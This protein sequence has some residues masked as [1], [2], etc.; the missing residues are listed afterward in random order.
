MITKNN[1]N[2][3]EIN[4]GI[5]F[6]RVILSFMVI[7]DHFYDYAI[8]SKYYYI[9]YYHIPT[10]FL[11]SFYYNYNTLTSFNINRIKS[12]FGRILIPYFS[13]CT[14]SWIINNIYY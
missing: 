7:L 9:L 11:I 10:F 2:K 13:W 8:L 6:L 3:K 4:I 12:R 5:S 1:Y 14:I